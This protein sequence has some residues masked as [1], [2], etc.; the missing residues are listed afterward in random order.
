MPAY[1]KAVATMSNSI[2]RMVARKETI[3]QAAPKPRTTIQRAAE[4][5]SRRNVDNATIELLNEALARV[6]LLCYERDEDGRLC[7]ADGRTGK[8]LIP[9][10]WGRGGY[11]RWGISVTEA[12]AMRAIMFARQRNGVA[13]FAF[14]RSRR[15]WFLNLVDYPTLPRL[16]EWVITLAEYRAVRE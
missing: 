6:T 1:T 10:P 8:V 15:A 5:L 4:T 11:K 16:S 7:N 13:L 3:A 12:D 14:D 2:I 9:L